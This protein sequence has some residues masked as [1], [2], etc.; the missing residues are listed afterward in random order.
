MVE[1]LLATHGT[2]F[3]DRMAPSE[4]EEFNYDWHYWARADQLPPPGD[5]LTWLIMAGRGFG[6][7]RTGAETTRARVEAGKA[8]RLALVGATTPDIRDIMIEG[9][10]GIIAISPPR[11]RPK[12]E[13]SKRRL[14]WPNGAIAT[15]FTA[16]EPDRLRG[17]QHDFAWSD[18]LASWKYGPDTWDN[19]QLGLRLGEPSQI[20]TTTPRPKRVVRDLVKNTTTVVTRGSTFANR[21]NLAPAFFSQ[22]VSRYAGTRL[23]RQEIS[24]ELLEDVP[25][26]LWRRSAFDV[27]RAAPDLTRVVVAIDPATTSGED[28]DETGIIVAGKGIDGLYYV[29]ADRSGRMTPNGWA[30]RALQAFADFKADRLIAESNQGGEMVSHTI[31]TKW[32]NA[33]IN[34]VHASRGKQAR[35]EPI[36]ALYEQGKVFHVEEFTDLEDQLCTWTPVDGASPDRLDALVY[37]LAELSQQGEPG[38]RFF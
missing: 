22:V 11:F 29:L 4:R 28:A 9:E 27:R 14:T 18:E 12:Y 2:A 24:G 33:P 16:E 8:G 25:G 13:P 34:L 10:S 23:G 32:Q 17:P 31:Q 20:V 30:D 37:A 15:T 5:W 38:L 6:K 3:Y 21:A 19:L 35:A 36:A 26:A 1:R 7:T